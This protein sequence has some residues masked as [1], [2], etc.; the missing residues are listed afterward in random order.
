VKSD[1]LVLVAARENLKLNR[2]KAPGEK[3][4]LEKTK[5]GVDGPG[6]EEVDQK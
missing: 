1:V 6:G 2:W 5:K 3:T 4:Y